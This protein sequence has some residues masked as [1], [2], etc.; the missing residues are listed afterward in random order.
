MVMKRFAYFLRYAL[1]ASALISCSISKQILGGTGELIKPGDKIG[2]MAVEQ[3]SQVPY[4]NIWWFCESIPDKHEPFSVSTDCEVPLVSN[5][6]INLGW[7]AKE[8]KLASNWDVMTY[9]MYID[10]YKIDL[11]AF[12][13]FETDY[14]AKGED[15]K[16]RNWIIT[17]KN[18]SPG[19]HTLRHS[20]TSETA[21]DD[22]WNINQPGTYEQ[23]VNFTVLE[24]VVYPTFSSNGT[25]GQHP[26]TSEKAQ[27]DFLLYLPNDF[28][29]DPQQEWPLIVYL[30]GAPLRGSTLE[31][32]RKESLPRRL[33]KENDLP[34]IIVSPLGDGEYEFWTKDE[35]INPLFTLLE[36]I[37]TVYSVDNKRIYLTGNDMGGNGVWTIGL[38]YPDYFAALAPVA[39][40]FGWPP[41]VPEN[42]CDLKDVPVWAFHGGRDD[43]IPVEAGQELVDS[44]NACGGNAQ[45]SVSQDMKI[46]VRVK[47]YAEPELFKWLLFQA[48]K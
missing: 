37:Q 1:I 20:W 35:M 28:G 10:D 24:K 26:Y 22:G 41:E 19:M 5:L 27:L 9:E 25:V 32:L 23:L 16:S 42:I 38:R 40:Y 36:E 21:V 46:D 7:I 15:N 48:M 12:N 44:L 30:H 43:I 11:E 3:S 2:K 45:F 17:L 39:G 4:Q 14:I 31:L 33:E 18:L 13:W 6:D 29:K 47:I 34:F 8:S